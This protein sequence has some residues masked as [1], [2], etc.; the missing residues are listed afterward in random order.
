MQKMCDNLIP[1]GKVKEE[2]LTALRLSALL[3][4]VGHYPFSH[5]IERLFSESDQRAKHINLGITLIKKS[6]IGEILSKNGVQITDVEKILLK[7]KDPSY[8]VYSYLLDSDL[9]VDKVDYLLRDAMHTGVAYG[10]IDVD[11]LIRTLTVDDTGMMAINEKGKHALENLMIARYHMFQC[12]YYHKVVAAFELMLRRVYEELL[13]GKKVFGLEEIL[14]KSE[15]N[16]G[17]EIS[18]FDDSYVLQ[19]MR[20]YK[21]RNAFLRELIDMLMRREPLSRVFEER[22]LTEDKKRPNILSLLFI[23]EQKKMCAKHANIDEK[24]VFPMKVPRIEFSESPIRVKRNG[25]S[26][27]LD[28]DETSILSIL[29]KHSFTSYRVYAKEEFSDSIKKAIQECLLAV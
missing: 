22:A 15:E 20:K 9:D 23:P 18:L 16:Q 19:A 2:D 25:D 12:V 28:E 10:S 1:Q 29:S 26:I 5:V 3:H 27:P 24:W 21:G 6:E 11:R 8:P 4:D 14:K 7:K 17:E 13:K